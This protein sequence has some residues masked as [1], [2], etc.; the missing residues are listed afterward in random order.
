MRT[1]REELADDL[2]VELHRAFEQIRRTDVPELSAA[3]LTEEADVKI[4]IWP[5]ESPRTAARDR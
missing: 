4:V 5:D 3:E 2:E 1:L